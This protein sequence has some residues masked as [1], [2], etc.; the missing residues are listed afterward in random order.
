[1]TIGGTGFADDDVVMVGDVE[2]TVESVTT[3]EIVVTLPGMEQGTYALNVMIDD[4]GYAL[5]R[6]S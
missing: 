1:M 5:R 2:A 4:S 6:Y 3:T